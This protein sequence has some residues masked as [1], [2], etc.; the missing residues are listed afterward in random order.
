MLGPLVICLWTHMA[1]SDY[2]Y[3]AMGRHFFLLNRVWM[4]P[5]KVTVPVDQENPKMTWP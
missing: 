3:W 5:Y 1:A 4:G 2:I